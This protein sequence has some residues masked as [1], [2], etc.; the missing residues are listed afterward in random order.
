MKL[1][2]LTYLF[3]ILLLASCDVI[4]PSEGI[5]FFVSV[6]SIALCANDSCYDEAY[7]RGS[8]SHDIVD[9]WV[10]ADDNLLGAFELPAIVPVLKSGNVKISVQGGIK[11]NGIVADSKQYDFF[12]PYH[13][14]LDGVPGTTIDLTPTVTYR[15]N[16]LIWN[17]NF[18]LENAGIKME[19][20]DGSDTNIFVTLDST[21]VFEGKGSG[22]VVLTNNQERYRG[23]SSTKIT[24]PKNRVIY[25]EINYKCNS[26]FGIGI[27]TDFGSTD[28]L[29]PLALILKPTYNESLGE[30]EWRKVYVDLSYAVGNQPDGYQQQLYFEMTNRGNVPAELFVDNIKIIFGK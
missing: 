13:L 25:A 7:I 23:V 11:S 21:E 4:N 2:L 6:P 17:E 22:K 16:L 28:N 9:A 15:T 19:S 1:S 20:Y 8:N 26:D 10:F 5:P 14:Y 30:Y 27:R 3:G 29:Y 24:F 12:E 18:D